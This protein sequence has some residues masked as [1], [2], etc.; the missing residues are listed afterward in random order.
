[1]I[2][3]ATAD[4]EDDMSTK[5]N[6]S[7]EEAVTI[8]GERAVEAAESENC[9]PTGRVGYNGATQG[10]ELCEW[11][12]SAPGEDEDGAQCSVIVYYYTTNEHER[13]MAESD[14][15]GSVVE[16]EIEGYEIV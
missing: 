2:K 4:E 12:A 16:W 10:D 9:E 6:L 7:R 5:G 15:D 11:S 1:M 13:E 3:T 14:G 8:I